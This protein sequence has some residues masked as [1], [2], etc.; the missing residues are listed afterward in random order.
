[1]WVFGA[2]EGKK[3][4]DNAKYLFLYVNREKADRIRAIWLT[5]S[6]DAYEQ[7]QSWGYEVYYNSSLIGKWLQLRA[8]VAFYTN[9]LIDFGI[10]P[11]IG[12]AKLIALW[13]G[14]GFK[15]IY[16][17]KYTGIKLK[18]KKIL[19]CL[20]SW[21]RRDIT[22]VTSH[23]AAAWTER[24]FTLNP[25]KVFIT[26]Q[27][28]N[29]AFNRIDKMEVL[30]GTCINPSKRLI[31]YMPTYRSNAMGRDA[32]QTIVENLYRGD[33]LSSWLDKTNSVFVVKPHPLTPHIELDNRSNFVILDYKELT[34]NQELLGVADILITD[35][36]SCFIDY[37]LLR[38]SIIF[39]TPDEKLFFKFSEKV[40]KDFFDIEHLCQAKDINELIEKL[41]SPFAIVADATNALF[42]DESIRGTCYSENVYNV[43]CE[44]IGI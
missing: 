8:G 33:E 14:M 31:L 9:G 7:V 42:E 24:A 39:Y 43:V 28:R 20:F 16:N 34:N 26:G 30:K 37:A 23:W 17:E 29:D 32:M 13:H 19:D 44:E 3:F 35:Y 2:W 6:P 27:P 22:I 10:F 18:I 15:K 21:T 5:D 11:M 40:D 4:D 1:M 36:S 12:G 38:R 41:S 25:N